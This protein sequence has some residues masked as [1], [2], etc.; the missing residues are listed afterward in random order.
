MVF[1]V[2]VGFSFPTTGDQHLD[3]GQGFPVPAPRS[4]SSSSSSSSPSKAACG[5]VAQNCPRVSSEF[6]DEH[7]V[8]DFNEGGPDSREFSHRPPTTHPPTS[9]ALFLTSP[10]VHVAMERSQ[11]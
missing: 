1:I 11:G 9:L 6:I 8:P 5:V 3:S 10:G 4:A 2:R 7:A